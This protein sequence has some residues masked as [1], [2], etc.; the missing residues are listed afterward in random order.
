M[1]FPNVLLPQC[2]IYCCCGVMKIHRVHL[3][4]GE[5]EDYGIDWDGP[6]PHDDDNDD[7][8]DD[9]VDDDNI[10]CD[11]IVVP[12]IECPLDGLHLDK[13]N[14]EIPPLADTTNYGI[15]LYEKTLDYISYRLNILL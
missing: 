12:E 10:N 1:S 13:L 5:R 14:D 7:V 3:W 6:V 15:D 9:V 11:S 4:Q 8:V 2:Y